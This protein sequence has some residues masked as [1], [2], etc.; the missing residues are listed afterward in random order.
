MKL[1]LLAIYALAF[2]KTSIS[3]KALELKSLFIIIYMCN[4]LQDTGVARLLFPQNRPQLTKLYN[5]RYM[6]IIKLIII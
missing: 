2:I 1:I 6:I 3:G 5:N 4:I